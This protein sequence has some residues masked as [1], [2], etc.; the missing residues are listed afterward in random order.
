MNSNCHKYGIIF[1]KAPKAK[2]LEVT[3]DRLIIYLEDGHTLDGWP[4]GLVAG[5]LH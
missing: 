3:K 2:S 1:L 4:K 5:G